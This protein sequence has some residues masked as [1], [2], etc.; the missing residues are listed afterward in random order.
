MSAER[1]ADVV[2]VGAGMAGAAAAAEL[3]RAG[4]SVCVVEARDRVGGR[5]HSIRD[6]CEQPVEAGAEF[7]HGVGA[8]TWPD[9]R[10][11]GVDVRPCPL[12]SGT[13]FNFGGRTLWLPWSLLHPGVWPSFPILW[14]IG[15][16]KGPDVSAR[17][18]LDRLRLRGRARLMAQMVLTGHLPGDLDQV[19]MQGLLDDN[20]LQLETGLNHRVAQG[21][22]TVVEHITR[23]L[24]IRFGFVTDTIHWGEGE[25]VVRASDGRELRARAVVTTLPLG[26]LRSGRVRFVPDLP[27]SKR[28][29]FDGLLAGP[30]LKILL[31]F[32]AAFWPIWLA[33][34]PCPVGPVTLYWPVF[35]GAGKDAPAVLT[36][37][38]TGPRAARLSAMSDAEA[39]DVVLADLRRLFPKS[40][41][42][43]RLLAHRRIDWSTDPFACGG[44]TLVCPGGAG[45]RAK[46]AA[47][48]TGT[49]FWAGSATA[50]PAI[51]ATVESAYL[52]GIRAAREA[53]ASL[54]GAAVGL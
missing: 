24:D 16:F 12:T 47:A 35:Y 27:A 8:A 42:H 34:L 4:H 30:V 9:A 54:Q 15:R 53:R 31:R 19:G 22:D 43:G 20:V 32:E 28:E 7:I 52:S 37:Y 50:T 18:F 5:V 49:L 14:W 23:G 29:A 2:V 26:V 46:L 51:A 21:Y 10:A 40:D 13:M 39:L 45:A 48:D 33:N 38:A 3:V 25:A 6:F 44:Y 1:V 36:A 41:P 11:A 17:E